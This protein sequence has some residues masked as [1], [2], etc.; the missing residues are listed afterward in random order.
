MAKFLIAYSKVIALR[1][2]LP[3]STSVESYYIEQYHSLLESFREVIGDD[4]DEF[5]VEDT[6]IKPRVISHG[7]SIGTRYSAKSYC[8][9]N[10]LLSKLEGLLNYITMQ[11][12]KEDKEKIIGFRS[13]Q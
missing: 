1:D 13:T 3:A 10:K 4:V 12:P 11:S 5:R 2:N 8:S 6:E 7:R 9:K